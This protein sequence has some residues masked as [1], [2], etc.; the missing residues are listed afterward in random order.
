MN[1]V[2]V[3]FV[4]SAL[5][6]AATPVSGQ[7]I[8]HS[9]NSY[10]DPRA[11]MTSAGWVSGAVYELTLSNNGG[12]EAQCNVTWNYVYGTS[13]GQAISSDRIVI[14]PGRSSTSTLRGAR[15]GSARWTYNCQ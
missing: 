2:F 8:Y 9:E 4:L 14:F 15:V 7:S 10:V 11:Q 6:A 12:A 3:F 1:K 13:G 5:T